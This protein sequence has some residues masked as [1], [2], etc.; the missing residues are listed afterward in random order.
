MQT[1]ISRIAIG[2]QAVL[3]LTAC[4]SMQK[5]EPPALK[6]APTANV[7]HGAPRPET[8]YALGRYYQGQIRYDQA[9]EAYR[10]LLE[11]SPNHAE[12]HN[13]LG[14]VLAAQGK[15]GQA[16]AELEQAAAN[17]PD[18]ARIRNNLGYAYLLQGDFAKAAAVLE[19]AAQLDPLNPRVQQNLQL[20]RASGG[21]ENEVERTSV[22]TKT[23]S[24]PVNVATDGMHLKT[25]APNVF[26]LVPAV[27]APVTEAAPVKTAAALPAASSA[28]AQ[29]ADAGNVE[30]RVRLEVSNGNG[31]TGMARKT[32]LE[33]QNSGYP[34][35]RLTNERPYRLAATEIQYRPGFEVQAR[36][37]Q[38]AL[39][40]GVPVVASSRLRSDVQ[41]RLALGKDVKSSSEL[42]AQPPSP[43][44]TVARSDKADRD[45]LLPAEALLIALST[46]ENQGY[47]K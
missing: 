35:A 5:E 33:L 37:L 13:A 24:A 7:R 18:S 41:V 16:I 44:Q 45:K 47:T 12:G 29:R 40:P 6:I 36:E 4:Q 46:P 30:K 38:T 20:A 31:V 14:M 21:V 8:L 10:G 3:C 43:S 32:S 1:R 2:V 28:P 34:K 19:T 25:V 11:A 22:E 42:V 17:A 15:Y 9:I 23:V 39:R 26:S 27:Q